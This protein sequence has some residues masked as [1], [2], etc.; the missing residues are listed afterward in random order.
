MIQTTARLPEYHG[1]HLK[2]PNEKEARPK[3]TP[4]AWKKAD[5]EELVDMALH[6]L[7][8]A[9]FEPIEWRAPLYRRMGVPVILMHHSYLIEDEK[10]DRASKLLSDLGL[11]ISAPHD[12]LLKTNGDFYAKARL[13]RLT[14]SERLG[15]VQYLMLYPLSFTSLTRSELITA[16]R[17]TYLLSPRCK[18]ILHP[19]PTAVFASILR[20][21][22]RYPRCCPTRGT[23]ET[24]LSELIGYHLYDL[25]DGYVNIDDE[26]LCEALEV[27]RRVADAVQTVKSWGWDCKWRVGEDWMGDA[28]ALVVKG[29]ADLDWLPWAS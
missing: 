23:L 14:H 2:T 20:M 21:M 4:I 26:E 15:S 10:L 29:S 19:S 3:H 27:D 13:H 24:D 1:I 25:Q 22:L 12:V 17:I 18:T 8:V 6:R 5:P 11:P 7:Q 28:L 9:G 16:P